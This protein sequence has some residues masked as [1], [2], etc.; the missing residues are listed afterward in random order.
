METLYHLQSM[1]CGAS[2]AFG[3]CSLP[4]HLTGCEA[5]MRTRRRGQNPPHG[6]RFSK[7]GKQPRQPK[8]KAGRQGRRKK[9]DGVTMVASHVTTNGVSLTSASAAAANGQ[10]DKFNIIEEFFVCL[11]CIFD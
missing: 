11:A 10:K 3:G 5:L 2:A 8:K 1:L 4:D 7:S 6:I 9:D